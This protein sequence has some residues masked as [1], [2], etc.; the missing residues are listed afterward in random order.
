[1]VNQTVNQTNVNQKNKVNEPIES[2][3]QEIEMVNFEKQE[4]KEP[5][6]KEEIVIRYNLKG[7]HRLP[8]KIA[9]MEEMNKLLGFPLTTAKIEKMYGSETRPGMNELCRI[10]IKNTGTTYSASTVKH[11]INAKLSIDNSIN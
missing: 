6:N 11:L 8:E 7:D 5:V 2:V 4:S 10:L 1:M 9:I 3:N